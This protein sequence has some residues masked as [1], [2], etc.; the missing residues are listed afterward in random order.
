MIRSVVTGIIETNWTDLYA[1]LVWV[2]VLLSVCWMIQMREDPANTDL[3]EWDLR[4]RRAG[5]F[6]V[7][8]GLIVSVLFGGSQGWT[9]W[10]PMVLIVFG[11][12]F[13]LAAAI[14][15]GYHRTQV[16]QVRRTWSARSH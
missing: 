2:S 1:V 12:D 5:I 16:R 8:A 3:P 10:P 4:L 6:M 13:Y 14:Y 11:F 15:S 9:P 7:V